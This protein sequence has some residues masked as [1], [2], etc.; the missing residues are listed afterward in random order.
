MFEVKYVKKSGMLEITEHGAIKLIINGITKLEYDRHS[1]Y[2]NMIKIY[3]ND[4]YIGCVFE[5]KE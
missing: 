3:R 5:D 1:R 2:Y 4:I